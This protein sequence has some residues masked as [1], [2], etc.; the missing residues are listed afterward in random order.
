M[1]T[2]GRTWNWILDVAGRGWKAEAKGQLPR[3]SLGL[4]TS[5]GVVDLLDIEGDF[6]DGPETSVR[7]DKE[8]PDAS[9]A[10]ESPTNCLSADFPG[11]WSLMCPGM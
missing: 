6:E 4:S 2:F 5:N 10:R 3:A 7:A 1:D 8:E 9:E 11:V